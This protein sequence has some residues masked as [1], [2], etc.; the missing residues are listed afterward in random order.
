MREQR[1]E[2]RE[3]IRR[4]LSRIA[5]FLRCS[6]LCSLFSVLSACGPRGGDK[7]DIVKVIDQ[8]VIDEH[9]VPVYPRKAALTTDTAR[10]FSLELPRRCRVDWDNQNVF[11]VV[12]EEE[13]SM[14]RLDAGDPLPSFNV[15]D[16]KFEKK[17][18]ADAISALV[19]GTGISVVPEQDIPDKL[20]ANIKSGSLEDALELLAKMARVYYY[21][22][23]DGKEL[24]LTGN[25]RWLVRMPRDEMVVMALIDA[26]HGADLNN[27]LINWEDKTLAFDGNYQTEKEVR[28]VVADLGSRSHL[29]AYDMDVYRVYPRTENPIVWMNMLSAF[30]GKNVKMSV[31]GVI[32]RALV[33]SP[34]IN[35]KTLQT[36]LA[37]QANL[38]LISQGTF[39]IPNN[40]SSRFDIGQCTKEE[41]L[42]T[43]LIVGAKGRYGDYGGLNKVDSKIVLRTKQ[44]EI[45]NYAVPSTAGDNIVIVGIPTHAFIQDPETTISPFAELVV[46]LSPKV[47]SV[48]ATSE[49]LDPLSGD[50]LREWLDE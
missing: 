38:V 29:I 49:S 33:V 11:S 16:Y 2:N 13:I 14:V 28:R 9:S 8:L 3:Q 5:V 15:K 10:R 50:E 42:E 35:T 22:D 44:G 37:Q 20:S 36:F 19:E 23:E 31:P 21:Y 24:R 7:Y 27:M 43:D 48:V 25:A 45:A 32:G 6:V 46:F 41:R 40:W 17:T 47:V 34:E 26:L 12:P 39:V 30:G 18:A 1:T 4:P